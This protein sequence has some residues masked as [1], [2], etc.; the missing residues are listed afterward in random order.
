[1]SS[2]TTTVSR[3]AL[4]EGLLRAGDHPGAVRALEQHLATQPRDARAHHLLGLATIGGVHPSEHQAAALDTALRHLHQAA[5]LDCTQHC[6]EVAALL[7]QDAALVRW[8]TQRVALDHLE[9]RLVARLSPAEARE[10][11]TL[12]PA[13]GTVWWEAL[14]ALQATLH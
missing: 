11:T 3:H 2:D 12:V 4:A 5:A 8:H 6:A 1:M 10:I 7:V 9:L 13:P 14:A